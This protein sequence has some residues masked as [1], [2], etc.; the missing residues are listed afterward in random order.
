MLLT[1]FRSFF[2]WIW[3]N[4]FCLICVYLLLICQSAQ[5]SHAWS[6]FSRS[7]RFIKSET[8]ILFQFIL[9]YLSSTL[10]NFHAMLALF[11][12]YVFLVWIFSWRD[13][14]QVTRTD[15]KCVLYIICSQL[16]TFEQVTVCSVYYAWFV[17]L[18]ASL[19]AILL[20][21]YPYLFLAQF[22]SL[23]IISFHRWLSLLL[24]LKAIA[25]I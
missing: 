5:L 20:R 24:G 21:T 25:S 10:M 18:L 8:R 3:V 19:Y 15:A 17:A 23:V 7:I 1:W 14:F 16:I 22:D 9:V 11:L 6:D 13:L 2:F 12:L 4:H